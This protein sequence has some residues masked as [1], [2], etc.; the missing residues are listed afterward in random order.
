[1]PPRSPIYH[2]GQLNC[3][4]MFLF[5]DVGKTA[6]GGTEITATREVEMWVNI[7]RAETAAIND[8]G[9]TFDRETVYAVFRSEAIPAVKGAN[10]CRVNGED[11]IVETQPAQLESW[12]I[13]K[14][15]TAWVEL[16]KSK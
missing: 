12:P 8:G 2:A 15:R 6:S 16:I 10:R 7:Q 11:Y 3:L 5:D 4:V 14:R 13:A 1:M 9:R